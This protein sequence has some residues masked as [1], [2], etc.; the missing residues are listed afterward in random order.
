MQLGVVRQKGH[1]GTIHP[2]RGKPTRARH[3]AGARRSSRASRRRR[4][5]SPT[6]CAPVPRASRI[7]PSVYFLCSSNH[8]GRGPG[9]RNRAD[10][11]RPA[12]PGAR[13]APGGGRGCVARPQT[14][15]WPRRARSRSTRRAQPSASA[16]AIAEHARR[17]C[18]ASSNEIVG[19]EADRFDRFAQDQ[20]G[21]PFAKQL[22][23]TLG[24]PARAKPGRSRAWV[25]P[26]RMSLKVRIPSWRAA[27]RPSSCT[28]S[29]RAPN[30]RP[31]A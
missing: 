9:G 10:P 20:L 11:T 4:P 7:R 24:V 22:R 21:Q 18:P 17:S 19:L 14:A 29:R 23:K 2:P 1:A 30:S 28:S 5:T 25:A 26:S 12:R 3:S 31:S 8:D 27:S 6:R 15:S 13:R 16:A